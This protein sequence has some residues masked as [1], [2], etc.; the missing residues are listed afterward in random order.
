MNDGGSRLSV[1]LCREIEKI[2]GNSGPLPAAYQARLGPAK[3]MWIRSGPADSAD[4]RDHE[5]WI[6]ISESQLK[7]EPHSSDT[8]DHF[9]PHR[10][11]FEILKAVESQSLESMRG[12]LHMDML[13]LL[14]DCG[15]DI[16]ALQSIVTEALAKEGQNLEEV[17]QDP[18]ETRH[19]LA[20]HGSNGAANGRA[21]SD[22]GSLSD[23]PL[24]FGEK[25][26]YFLDSGFI[27]SECAYLGGQL[28]QVAARYLNQALKSE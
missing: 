9:D 12:A 24:D 7:F 6:E 14:M 4:P 28:V 23:L 17:F 5:I 3:G 2:R 10:W 19:W 13:P 25:A 22:L 16:A 27:A 21:N 20:G 15:V 1:G 26:I 8:D 18:V 11:T